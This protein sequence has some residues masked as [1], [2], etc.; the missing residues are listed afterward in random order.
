M[1]KLKNDIIDLD[2][3]AKLIRKDHAAAK[4]MLDILIQQLGNDKKEIESAYQKSNYEKLLQLVHKLHGGTCYCG[5]PRLKEASANLEKK[6]KLSSSPPII[7]T[8]YER[9]LGEI[10][11]VMKVYKKLD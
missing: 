1:N 3:G 5:T 11:A 10:Q 4:E 2:L 9:L 8:D 6:L 7:K